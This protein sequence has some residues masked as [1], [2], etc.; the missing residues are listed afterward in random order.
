MPPASV[1]AIAAALAVPSA[2]GRGPSSDS[3][4]TR[5]CRTAQLTVRVARW[6]V[7][8]THTGGFIAFTNHSQTPCRL[9]GWPRLA[10]V[11]AAGSLD[12]IQ[13]RA[14]S[15]SA[16]ESQSTVKTFISHLMRGS[17]H[18]QNQSM[19]RSPARSLPV[20]VRFF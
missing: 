16:S 13:I 4:A 10:A 5:N 1:I 8:L 7:G 17:S 18:S 3:L 20:K 11:T 15:S 14:S 19:D 9:A 2:A 12:A 6:F